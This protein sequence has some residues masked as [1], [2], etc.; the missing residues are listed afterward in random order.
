MKNLLTVG[1]RKRKQS[2]D[3]GSFSRKS[4]WFEPSAQVNHGKSLVSGKRQPGS[5]GETAGIDQ[6]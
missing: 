1:C 5:I 6:K 4:G 2:S 3:R